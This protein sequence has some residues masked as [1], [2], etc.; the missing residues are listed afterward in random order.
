[1]DDAEGAAARPGRRR[2]RAR[3]TPVAALAAALLPLLAGAGC[4]GKP[5]KST[6]V[7]GAETMPGYRGGRL[8]AVFVEDRSNRPVNES[9]ARGIKA[10]LARCGV[11]ATVHRP[12]EGQATDPALMAG[13]DAVLSMQQSGSQQGTSLVAGVFQI[14]S[15]AASQAPATTQRGANFAQAAASAADAAP[16]LL[17]SRMTESPT[18]SE[19]YV[20]YLTDFRARR[21]VWKAK[22]AVTGGP[23]TN[24]NRNDIGGEVARDVVK[25]MEAGNVV[26]C[27]RTGE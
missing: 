18:L 24:P 17:P 20:F 26:S 11:R 1:M 2:P 13:H 9:Y 19:D 27:P 12:A 10:A 7:S 15:M 25:A 6:T 4:A 8:R 5:A 23:R 16:S 22:V 3:T 14:A 21:V